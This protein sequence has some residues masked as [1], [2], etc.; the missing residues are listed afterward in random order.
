MEIPYSA[1]NDLQFLHQDFVVVGGVPTHVLTCGR[2]LEDE[3]PGLIIIFIPGNPGAIDYYEEFLKALYEGLQRAV[4]IWGI[5]HA[6]HAMSP[7]GY[8]RPKIQGNEELYSL[9][10]QVAHK[11]AFIQKYVPANREVILI[12]HSIGCYVVL[13]I[14]RRLPGLQV[15]RAVLLFPTVER[16]ASTPQGQWVW[17]L[18]TYLRYP[19]LLGVYALSCLSPQMQWRVLSWYFKDRPVPD[20]VYRG[21]MHLFQPECARLCMLMARDELQKVHA[22]DEDTVATN[23]HRITF[24]YGTEDRWCPLSYYQDMKDRFPEGDIRLCRHGF[25][26]AFVM[27]NSKE[28]GAL[29]AAW[30]LVEVLGGSRDVHAK[31]LL[32]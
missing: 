21:C 6:G 5:S 13:E 2:W 7:P 31:S 28:V 11:V 29:V 10:G 3:L 30:I 16:M 32:V 12:G 9:E 19:T 8:P 15:P 25:Q 27:D 4:P 24:Y 1:A 14:L 23:L 20:C 18:L 26:H 17:P 22:L